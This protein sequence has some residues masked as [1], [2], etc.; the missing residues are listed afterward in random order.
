MTLA[1]DATAAFSL[2]VLAAFIRRPVQWKYVFAAIAIITIDIF[3][4]IGAALQGQYL[5]QELGLNW[6]WFGKGASLAFSI[7]LLATLPELR[8]SVGLTFKQRD[9]SRRWSQWLIALA[10]GLTVA[11][12]W[13]ASPKPFDAETLLFQLTMPTLSEELLYRGILL[14]VLARAWPDS[15]LGTLLPAKWPAIVV[16]MIF[17]AG[18]AF[19]WTDGLHVSLESMLYTTAIGA[20][21][22]L[23]RLRSGSLLYCVVAHS[24]VNVI[25][26]GLPMLY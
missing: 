23:I 3:L 16:T 19:T 12:T 17:G 21:I 26:T 10:V 13:Q 14:A 8:S 24:I 9:G 20:L 2:I 11:L 18:H 4:V 22:M 15:D 7:L 1:V 6:N 5:A 25:A